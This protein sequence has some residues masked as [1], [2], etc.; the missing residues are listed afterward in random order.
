M[1][2]KVLRIKPRKIQFLGGSSYVSLPPAW[3][4]S[5][6]LNKGKSVDMEIDSVGRLILTP[7]RE[8]NA[9]AQ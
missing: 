5:N 6:E 3:I 4:Y 9:T 1:E 8:K 2:T 7:S